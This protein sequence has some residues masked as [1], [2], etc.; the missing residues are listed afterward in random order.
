MTLGLTLVNGSYATTVQVQVPQRFHT[1][2]RQG[3]AV[4]GPCRIRS[5]PVPGS[6]THAWI[7]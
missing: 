3:A 7:M 2:K 4:T 6:T 1:V 5:L